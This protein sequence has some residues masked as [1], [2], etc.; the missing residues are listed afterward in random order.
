MIDIKMLILLIWIKLV[1]RMMLYDLWSPGAGF[2]PTERQT[3]KKERIF[4]QK[5]KSF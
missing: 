5:K 3:V 2:F 4:V 1:K